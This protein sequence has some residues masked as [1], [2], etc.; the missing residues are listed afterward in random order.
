M[1]WLTDL[2]DKRKVNDDKEIKKNDGKCIKKGQT[3]RRII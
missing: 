3:K 1:F 2:N